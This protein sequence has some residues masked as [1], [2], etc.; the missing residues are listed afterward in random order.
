MEKM[1]VFVWLGI[2]V[3]FMIIEG[4]TV[5]LTTIWFAAGALIAMVVALFKVP[6]YVQILVFLVASFALLFTT[7]KVLVEKLKTGKEKT[8]TEALIGE[9]AKVITRIEPLSVGQ[10]RINGLDWSAVALEKDKVFEVGEV[11]TIE[12]IQGV[13]LVVK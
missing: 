11:V 9:E 4:L 13:K 6:L 10:V 12:K 7:R 1:L 5:G 2:A 3:A 8:N